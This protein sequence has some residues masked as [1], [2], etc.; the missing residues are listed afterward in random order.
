M[1]DSHSPTFQ[2]SLQREVLPKFGRMDCPP[3][4]STMICPKNVSWEIGNEQKPQSCG[5]NVILRFEEALSGNSRTVMSSESPFASRFLRPA[6]TEVLLACISPAKTNQ[7]E[8]IST[9]EFAVRMSQVTV[10]RCLGIF[11]W[12][13]RFKGAWWVWET[14]NKPEPLDGS[15]EEGHLKF[16]DPAKHEARCKLIKTNAK[17]NEQAPRYAQNPVGRSC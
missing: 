2:W 8:S 6:P 9:L 5:D 7:E 1:M 11:F 10:V 4:P 3:F 14:F 13:K 15:W 12:T 16:V 17:K